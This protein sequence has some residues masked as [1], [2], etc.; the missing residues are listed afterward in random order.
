[1]LDNLTVVEL[2]G[3]VA[4]GAAGDM[5]RRLGARVERVDAAAGT[6]AA[7]PG[8]PL[9]QRERLLEILRRD[10]RVTHV[11]DPFGAEAI[12]LAASADIVIADPSTDPRWPVGEWVDEY[13][14]DVGRYC[15][16]SWVTISP[17]G[18][19]GEF[20]PLPGGELIA[21][22]SGGIAY[23]LR[24]SAGRPMKPAGFGI[25][26]TAGQYAALAGLHGILRYEA[27]LGPAHLDVS[28][29]DT[30]VAT[31]VF[32][33]CSQLLFDCSRAGASANYAA[34][35]GFVTCADGLVWIVV[36][37]DHHWEGC[38]RALGSPDWATVITSAEQRHAQSQAIRERLDEWAAN[39]SA[40]ECA[41]RLQ[42][43][44]VP[45]TTVNSCLDLL[46]SEGHDVRRGFFESGGAERLPGLPLT[47]T[48][49]RPVDGDPLISPVRPYRVVELAQVM[50]GPLATAWLGAMGIE[51]IKLEEPDRLDVYRRVGPFAGNVPN[52]ELGAYFAF[53]N[54]SKRSHTVDLR[55]PEGRRRFADLVGSA[56]AVVTNL[57]R[58]RLG[59]L[60]LTPE[61]LGGTD[62]PVAV[63]VGGFG[64][65]T[66]H[67]AYRAYGLNIQAA[68]GV[69]HLTRD[70]AGVP[71]NFGTSWAD[72]LTSL[73]IAAT[74]VAQLRRPRGLRQHVDVSMVEVV[75]GHFPEYFAAA[76]SGGQEQVAAE[77]RMDHAVPHGIYRCGEGE[78]WI[79]VAVETDEQWTEMVKALGSPAE[80]ADD[81][82]ASSARRRAGE[83]DLDARI[84]QAL[85]F[86]S[87]G[88]VFEALTAAGVPAS[89][90]WS[91][92]ELISLPHLRDRCLFQSLRHP[93][94]GLRRVLGL[95]WRIVGSEPVK[96]TP[97]PT[98]GQH[99]TADPAHWWTPVPKG[100]YPGR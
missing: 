64:A 52:P 8:G 91:A 28:V 38:V 80:L 13:L 79:A 83:D 2:G 70:R 76:Q 10:K 42:S 95:P 18:L 32:L 94:W 7:A 73:W 97:S 26:I 63:S 58:Q 55:E 69:L 59:K 41:R 30:V 6:S 96:I 49:R 98:L 75:A 31:G 17:F 34:P 20:R 47:V 33:E 82:F 53:V 22:A 29:Q 71:R 60:G 23:Y 11:A 40:R 78:D 24:S 88:E 57:S 93:A 77:N 92:R 61:R 87:R 84:E 36:L 39:L 54:H 12:A 44:G 56:D 99:T 25:S 62:G 46:A 86:R 43:E 81:R 74:T 66:E 5:L 65:S 1:M 16:K 3:G 89:P 48:D 67:A 51:V 85:A 15:R 72:P 37:E 21:A 90:V 50:V 19:T 45:A 68:G 9:T 27:G 4:T 35:V 100:E 14:A